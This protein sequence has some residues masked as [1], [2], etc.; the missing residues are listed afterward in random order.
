MPRRLS[1]EPNEM[2]FQDNLSGSEI[3]LQYRMPTTAERAGY[4]NESFQRKGRKLV[5]RQVETRLKYGAKILTGI[6]EG[7]FEIKQ[8]GKWAPISSDP[9]SD[10]YAEDWNDQVLKYGADLIELLAIRV[11]DAPVQV[12]EEDEEDA[13]QAEAEDADPNS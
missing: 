13:D 2:T 6:R 5:S 11:F 1:D 8:D 4:T 12:A 10:N 9:G 3:V 7:D